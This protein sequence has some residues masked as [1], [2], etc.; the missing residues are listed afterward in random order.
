[1][2]YGQ[3]RRK[4]LTHSQHREHLLCARHFTL[5]AAGTT[6]ETQFLPSRSLQS[7]HKHYVHAYNVE[8]QPVF[9]VGGHPKPKVLAFVKVLFKH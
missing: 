2:L 3:D 1:M 6:D 8:K 9:L 7:N 4:L 5:G